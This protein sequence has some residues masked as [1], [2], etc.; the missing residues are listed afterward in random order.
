PAGHQV[1]EDQHCRHDAADLDH[2][3]DGVPGHVPRV[4]LAEGVDGG[5]T[6]DGRVEQRGRTAARDHVRLRASIWNC[7][8][9]GPSESAGKYSRAPTIR[10]TAASRATNVTECVA[11]VPADS[12]TDFFRARL[13]AMASKGMIM[14][15]RPIS[16]A[17]P[18]VTLK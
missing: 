1:A 11:R 9:I 10:M 3:H 16:M 15:K 2:E 7:S 18:P 4:E 12:G 17:S 8:T 13:P 5:A 6:Q 14:R